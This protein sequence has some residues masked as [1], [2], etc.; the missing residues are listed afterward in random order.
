MTERDIFNGRKPPAGT[1]V[2]LVFWVL[3]CIV[4]AV[5]DRFELALVA[6]LILFPAALADHWRRARAEA[7]KEIGGHRKT[8]SHGP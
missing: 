5:L 2:M 1:I 7:P 8:G 4:I 3:F 6:A